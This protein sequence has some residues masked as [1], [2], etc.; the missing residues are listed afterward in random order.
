MIEQAGCFYCEQW[1]EEVGDAYAQTPEGRAAPLRQVQL[2][3][4]MP[5]DLAITRRAV[6]TPTFIL[7]SEGTEIGRIEGYPGEDFFWGLLERMIVET[8]VDLETGA[9][10]VTN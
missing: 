9:D 7:V 4:P 5:D 2:S 8:G 6:Y 1:H 3:Q 10:P